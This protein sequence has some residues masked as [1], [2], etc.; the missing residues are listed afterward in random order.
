MPCALGTALVP[1]PASGQMV[2]MQVVPKQPSIKG[3]D[4]LFSGD[5]YID[6]IARGQDPSRIQ[7]SAVHF[8]P[9]ARTA[10]HAHGLG[11]TLLVIEGVGFVQSRGEARHEIRA[12]D[13]LYASPG[14]EHWHGA[15]SAHFMTHISMTENDPDRPDRWGS[16]V[17]DDEYNG[18]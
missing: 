13:I 4:E 8:T 17:T 9:G 2:T 10:W 12:G 11:Q 6:P 14:E 3:P 7:V 18:V 5:V 16:H 1:V 15:A